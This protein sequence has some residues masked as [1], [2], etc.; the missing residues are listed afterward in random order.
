MDSAQKPRIRVVALTPQGG[1]LARTLGRALTGAGCWLPRAQ[2]GA[3]PEIKTFEHVAQVFQEA[4]PRMSGCVSF[5]N[6]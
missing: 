6:F 3:D 5:K 1:A 2:A 4:F